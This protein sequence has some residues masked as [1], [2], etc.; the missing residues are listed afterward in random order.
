MEFEVRRVRP[1]DWRRYRTLRLEALKDSPLAFVE[2]YDESILQPDSF[3]KDRTD[4][5]ATGSLRCTFGAFRDATMVGKASCFV[6][7]EIPEYV[8]AHVVGVYVTPARRGTGVAEAVMA[9]AIGWARDKAGAQRV[10]LFV[11]ETNDRAAAFYRRIGFVATGGTM[12]YPP[13]PTLVEREFV[14]QS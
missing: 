2:Q 6:E 9:A 5:S 7:T 14:Y 8:S 11:T 12:A 3:W 10:R 4:R 13:D 1:D